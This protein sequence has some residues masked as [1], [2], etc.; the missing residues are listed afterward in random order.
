MLKFW[1]YCWKLMNLLEM[2]G[3][4]IWLATLFPKFSRSF[5]DI[6]SIFRLISRFY[7]VLFLNFSQSLLKKY[8]LFLLN[9][10]ELMKIYFWCPLRKIHFGILQKFLFF[11][12]EEE[13]IFIDFWWFSRISLSIFKLSLSFP[14]FLFSFCCLAFHNS[15]IIQCTEMF[16][17]IISYLSPQ[18][19]EKDWKLFQ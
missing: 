3:K 4:F 1:F 13:F 7:F 15:P 17:S 10:L 11:S 8:L 6:F 5:F 16:G 14:C 2:L 18:L 19:R 9:L 12:S